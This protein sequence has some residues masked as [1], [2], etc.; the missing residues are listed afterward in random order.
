MLNIEDVK[1]ILKL[2]VS[3]KEAEEIRDGFRVLSEVIFESWLKE[4]TPGIPPKN[5][6]KTEQ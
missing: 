1:K 2:P 4:K 6:K 3:D 5:N